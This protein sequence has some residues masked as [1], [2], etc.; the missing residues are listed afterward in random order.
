MR[1]KI[2]SML[3][4]AGL[5]LLVSA[6]LAYGG[7]QE[8]LNAAVNAHGRGEFEEAIRLYTK[9]LEYSGIPDENR[10]KIYFNRGLAYDNQGR[11]DQAIANYSRA[12]ELNPDYVSAYYNR[13]NAYDNQGRYHQA[14]ADYS[15][16]I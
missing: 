10:S 15:R 7:L 6:S 4:G 5:I 14:I 1:C 2:S 11:Y 13:G 8:D 9:A 3:G 16:A 12:I